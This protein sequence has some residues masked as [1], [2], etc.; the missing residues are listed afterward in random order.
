V[1][2]HGIM[3]GVAIYSE[4]ST[5]LATG[6]HASLCSIE[7]VHPCI[8]CTRES[9]ILELFRAEQF[10]VLIVM[11]K[12]IP[13]IETQFE[14]ITRI[15]KQFNSI[16]II[17][18]APQVSKDIVFRSVKS[19]ANGFLSSETTVQELTEAV[20]TIRGGHEFFSSSITHLLVHDY[21]ESMRGELTS[22]E[23]SKLG[24]R[25]VEVLSLWGE[26]YMNDEI[27]DRL[28]ISVR[29][30]ESHKNHIMQKLGIRTTVDLLKFAI[31]NNIV[32]I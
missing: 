19:G 9:E 27:A 31:R 24:K 2:G 23:L 17:V 20:Y 30:V 5:I 10:S 3:F 15:K 21:V 16:R 6:I 28:F 32:S 12:H 11:L 14:L 29:T 13:N 1:E 22:Q 8:C 4:T 26:G 25:E 7:D 18:I